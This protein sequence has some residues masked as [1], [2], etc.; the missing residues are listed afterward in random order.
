MCMCCAQFHIYAHER[1]A[2][3]VMHCRGRR[4][5][6]AECRKVVDKST[7]AEIPGVRAYFRQSRQS[8]T[9]V[10][11]MLTC[12][13]SLWPPWRSKF[14]HR[15]CQHSVVNTKYTRTTVL[16][17]STLLLPALVLCSCC[18]IHTPHQL[19]GIAIACKHQAH[20]RAALRSDRSYKTI[21]AAACQC[22]SS[23][24]SRIDHEHANS[25]KFAMTP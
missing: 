20:E 3:S 11:H 14:A 24:Q 6:V 10:T 18:T 25:E 17:T 2:P 9:H 23:H 5:S 22:F 7:H 12:D 13:M 8:H 1:D 4:L 16:R 19:D 21:T 15:R